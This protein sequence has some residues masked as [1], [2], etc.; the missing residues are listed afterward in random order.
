MERTEPV[1]LI[2]VADETLR[3]AYGLLLAEQGYRVVTASGGPE[4]VSKVC[5]VAP[6]VLILDKELLWGGGDG[7]LE[8]LRGNGTTLWPPV[9]L[10]THEK[11][12]GLHKSQLA[13]VVACL[14]KPVEFGDLV[15]HVEIARMN[16][17][18][19][20][21]KAAHRA[22]MQRADGL[23]PRLLNGAHG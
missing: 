23:P 22:A 18:T 1:I 16:C 7:V 21:G 15:E 9:I 5:W 14:R 13:P 6:E 19:A 11:S 20:G 12:D 8:V 2:A 10:L 17:Q 3:N 4:C